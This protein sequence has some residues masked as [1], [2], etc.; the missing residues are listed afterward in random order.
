MLKL[1]FKKFIIN[2]RVCRIFTRETKDEQDCFNRIQLDDSHFT[3]I[4][5][6][7]LQVNCSFQVAEEYP[8]HCV[9]VK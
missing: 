9:T 5:K 8:S 2:S 3:M 6:D 4:Y 1:A 7:N